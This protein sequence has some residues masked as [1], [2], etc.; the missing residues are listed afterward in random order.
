MVVEPVMLSVP[1]LTIEPPFRAITSGL[2][3]VAT[4]VSEPLEMVKVAPLVTVTFEATWLPPLI[5]G[6]P[7]DMTT[8]SAAAGIVVAV[9]PP[10]D[11]F[12]GVAQSELVPPPHA[13]VDCAKRPFAQIRHKAINAALTRFV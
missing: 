11:Q 5:V 8:I 10:T 4:T 9:T 13:K 7:D 6:V 12:A 3:T 2:D 1:L